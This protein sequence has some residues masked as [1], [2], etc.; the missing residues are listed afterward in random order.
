MLPLKIIAKTVSWRSISSKDII[1]VIV[2]YYKL[3]FNDIHTMFGSLN[4]VAVLLL[5]IF[6]NKI[7]SRARQY[8]NQVKIRNVCH[9]NG[10][11]PPII[12]I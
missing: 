8:G 5:R 7:V 9:T 3:Q 1:C 2:L 10:D 4:L 6:I 12:R 11:S